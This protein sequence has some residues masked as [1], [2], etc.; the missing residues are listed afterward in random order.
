MRY[1]YKFL[2]NLYKTYE[3]E[4]VLSLYINK[5]G[6]ST[7][8]NNESAE[9]NIE[10]RE[11]EENIDTQIEK[12]FLDDVDVPENETIEEHN[13][14]VKRY[15]KIVK[16]LKKRYNY[17]CQLCGYIFHMDNGNDYCEAH[18]IKMLSQDGSQG[19]ESIII[20]CA[21]H[22]PIFHNATNNCIIGKLINGKRVIKIGDEEFIVQF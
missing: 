3:L 18:H 10:F 2:S 11:D 19:P 20:L 7:I 17:R 12:G 1:P 22:H 13:K 15:K 8:I 6:I 9:S 5:N 16:E 21:N 4:E 14:R